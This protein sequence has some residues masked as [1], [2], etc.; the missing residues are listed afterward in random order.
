MDNFSDSVM[1]A[2]LPTTTDWCKTPL[3]HM[4]LVYCGTVDS[5]SI[6]Q[7]NE[8]TKLALDMAMTCSPMT[9]PVTG[10]E[11]FGDEGDVEVLTLEPI[12]QLLAMRSVFEDWNA[13]EFSFSPHCTVGPVGSASSDTPR[14]LTFDRICVCWGDEQTPF[15]M[16]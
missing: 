4:T 6:G 5:L 11:H 12:P 3:P 9:I 15:K 13:S 8:L 14:D 16:L 2:L 1:V 7:R 10:V